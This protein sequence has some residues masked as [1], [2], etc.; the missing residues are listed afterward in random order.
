MRTGEALRQRHAQALDGFLNHGFFQQVQ[1]GTVTTAAR[2]AYFAYEHRFVEQ[3]V[4]VLAHV[5]TKAPTT[6]SRKHLVTMLNGLVT[7]QI[8]LFDAIFAQIGRPTQPMPQAVT[9][10]CEGMTAIAR[11]GSYAQGLAAMLAAEWTY[12]EVSRR[13]GEV[14]VSDPLLADWFDLHTHPKFLAGVDWLE[15]E[16][17]RIAGGPTPALSEAFLRAIA[18][19]VAFHEAPLQLASGAAPPTHPPPTRE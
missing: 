18:L 3:A 9:E 15:D 4:V 5:L 12:A 19:E 13:L 1:D 14:K 17:D 10:F 8:T 16:L 11:D 6:A 2:D 7:D